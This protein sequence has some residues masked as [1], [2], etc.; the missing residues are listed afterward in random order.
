[1]LNSKTRTDSLTWLTRMVH[2]PWF[3]THQFLWPLL[4]LLHVDWSANTRTSL[5]IVPWV[6]LLV[7]YLLHGSSGD[8]A[9][10]CTSIEVVRSREVESRDKLT[11]FKTLTPPLLV[12][13]SE[14]VLKVSPS[15]T[16]LC[17]D[18]I[19]LPW[20]IRSPH[21]ITSSKRLETTTVNYRKRTNSSWPNLRYYKERSLSW[22][23]EPTTLKKVLK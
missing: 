11:R 12:R 5:S 4:K 22:R 3:T 21:S 14:I 20:P 23:L 10:M 17:S 1:L 16:T 18:Q 8:C 6:L 9:V 15:S 13:P 7:L 2:T 19:K